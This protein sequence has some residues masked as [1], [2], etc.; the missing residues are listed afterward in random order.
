MTELDVVES[1]LDVPPVVGIAAREQV[2]ELVVLKLGFELGSGP[3]VEIAVELVVLAELVVLVV[4]LVVVAVGIGSFVVVVGTTFA[5]ELVELVIELVVAIAIAPV[6]ELV[7]ELVI[8][9][10]MAGFGSSSVCESSEI[11]LDLVQ[12]AA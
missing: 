11:G 7:V 5:V 1:G 8:E 9:R 12:V 10:S 3:V 2:V 4:E 6:V